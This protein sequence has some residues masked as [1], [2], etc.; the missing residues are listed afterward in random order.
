MPPRVEMDISAA[1]DE[2]FKIYPA[3]PRWSPKSGVPPPPP[4]T[5]GTSKRSGRGGGYPEGGGQIL[6]ENNNKSVGSDSANSKTK[7]ENEAFHIG[8]AQEKTLRTIF[9]LLDSGRSLFSRS[10]TV[11]RPRPKMG[12]PLR[13]MPIFPATYARKKR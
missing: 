8:G 7:V 13:H 4:P 11:L 2:S 9:T 1:S 10:Y 5:T 12:I 6:F 3:D